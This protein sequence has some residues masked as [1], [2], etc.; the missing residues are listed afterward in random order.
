MK[1]LPVDKKNFDKAFENALK[2]LRD[3]K[4]K[5]RNEKNTVTASV[6]DDE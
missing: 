3:E 4:N 5:A 6:G 1:L 2:S